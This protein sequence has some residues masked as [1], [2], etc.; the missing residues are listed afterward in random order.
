MSAPTPG[1]GSTSFED[2]SHEQMLAWLDQANSG[3]VRSAAD[4]LT[5]AAKEIRKIG[6]EL[7][8]RPQ[9]VDWKGEGA[10]V[11]RTWAGD[12]ANST[13][14]LG[15]FSD[16]AAKWL[17]QASNAIAHAQASIPRDPKTAR[18]DLN[19][20]T[21]VHNAPDATPA[22][23]KSATELAAF[24]A[25]KE[26][27]RR[28]AASQMLKLGQSYRLSATQL[29]GLERPVFP[30]PPKAVQPPDARGRGSQSGIARP[31]GGG[32]RILVRS[33]PVSGSP[34]QEP[35]GHF[36]AAEFQGPKPTSHD[37]VVSGHT[38]SATT[39]DPP[40]RMGVDSLSA[41]PQVPSTAA[42]SGDGVS[43]I[44]QPPSTVTTPP[45]GA[46]PVFR[47][48][49]HTGTAMPGRTVAGGGASGSAR[50]EGTVAKHAGPARST[51]AGRSAAAPGQGTAVPSPG[52]TDGRSG[53]GVV[54]GRPTT[55]STGRSAG[56][57]PRGTVVGAENAAA[58]GPVGSTAAGVRGAGVAGN[59][60]AP[61]VGGRAVSP[62]GGVVGGT[63]QQPGRVSSSPCGVGGT[64][65][66]VGAGG[67]VRDGVSGG[68]PSTGRLGTDRG[69]AAAPR[70]SRSRTDREAE[71]RR[72][73]EKRRR[74][75]QP[76]T[77]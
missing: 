66:S 64:G 58:R 63:P 20:A 21:P 69:G 44:G 27:I 52:R 55:P 29:E 46:M 26:K 10:D 5:A 71:D 15:D 34:V 7:K 75:E 3:T 43:G 2:M 6:E 56:A 47:G 37:G 22:T 73:R 49:T 25:A 8:V 65:G 70:G 57:I 40:V 76:T 32:S 31:D 51:S 59:G 9:H 12:L 33:D 62:R 18:A 1:T 24:A 4:R 23:T 14:R 41:P 30:P 74:T 50:P 35:A 61:S 28:E 17:G 39:V 13:L 45:G 11:F 60:G 48:D 72:L 53:N 19:A 54:G 68:T 38:L 16:D 77:D 36:G 67:A 42:G